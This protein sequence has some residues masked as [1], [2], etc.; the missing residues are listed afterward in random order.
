MKRVLVPIGGAISTIIAVYA[1]L[2]TTDVNNEVLVTMHSYGSIPKRIEVS[3]K[4]KGPYVA[5]NVTLFL[6]EYNLQH[7]CLLR[8]SE[9][10]LPYLG[11][12]EE[13]P[14]L[15][16]DPSPRTDWLEFC[17][18]RDGILPFERFAANGIAFNPT[19]IACSGCGLQIDNP[20]VV[21]DVRSYF[22]GACAAEMKV[23]VSSER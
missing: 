5:K 3:I 2:V 22:G 15:K 9:R 16:L 23:C 7:A 11:V 12:S 18:E 4:N 1:L 10:R 19:G 8:K 20:S 21:R 14:M 17:V 6:Y 13:V